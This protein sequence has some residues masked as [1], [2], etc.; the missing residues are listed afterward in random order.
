MI[1]EASGVDYASLERLF[2]TLSD[3][4]RLQLLRL[5]ADGPIAV[6]TLVDGLGESQPKISRH[7]AYMRESGYV[8]PR[9]DGKWIYYCIH[10][11]EDPAAREILRTVLASLTGVEASYAPALKPRVASM[12]RTPRAKASAVVEMT[13]ELEPIEG[14][15]DRVEEMPYQEVPTAVPERYDDHA[16]DDYDDRVHSEREIEVFLL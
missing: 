7:L 2:L 1:N 15:S 11:P 12:K 6:G 5:M 14:V 3:K 4:T 8:S 10:E 16:A 9:R 13:T